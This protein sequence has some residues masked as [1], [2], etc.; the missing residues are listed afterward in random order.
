MLVVAVPETDP[1]PEQAHEEF[2]IAKVKVSVRKCPLVWHICEWRVPALKL[3]NC[4]PIYLDDGFDGKGDL[5]NI[6]VR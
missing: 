3:P 2:C 1:C 4:L 5:L 6:K